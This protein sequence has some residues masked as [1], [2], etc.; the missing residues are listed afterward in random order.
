MSVL[1]TVYNRLSV[2]NTINSVL[3]QTFK[4]FEFLIIDNASDDGTYEL[5]LDFADKDK[6][7]IVVRNEVNRGQTYSLQRGID[8]AKGKYIARIDA[9]D[10]MVQTRLEKQYKFM[11]EHPDYGVCGTW[12]RFITD[13][14]KLA[15]VIPTCTT[16]EGLRV[17]Q[18]IGCGLFHPSVIMRS[19]VLREHNLNYSTAYSMAEDYYMWYRIMLFSKGGSIGEPLTYYRRGNNNDS[20]K[21][22]ETTRKEALEIRNLIC[23]EDNFVGKDEM[24]KILHNETDEPPT[25]SKYLKTK[26]LYKV[27]LNKNLS[28]KHVDYGIV[29]R[30]I[31]MSLFDNY[32]VQ[33]KRFWAKIAYRIYRILRS[34]RYA[35]K[36]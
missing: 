11:E 26:R 9:D 30:C 14:D 31:R 27:Y 24:Q 21:H 16:D 36:R 29:K 12:A 34:F 1:L 33:N 18:R 23:D 13:E 10:L 6:R 19:N 2:K 32:I 5:L 28:K 4:D 3:N 35:I 17:Y 20:K 15:M 22:A 7:I 8:L 25:I